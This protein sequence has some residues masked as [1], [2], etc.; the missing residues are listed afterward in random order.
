MAQSPLERMWRERTAKI[1]DEVRAAVRRDLQ[2]VVRGGKVRLEKGAGE[3]PAGSL[4]PE[5]GAPSQQA[6]A[7]EAL[8]AG[9]FVNIHFDGV[10]RVRRANAAN[11]RVAHGYVTQAVA[12]GDTATIYQGGRNGHVSGQQAGATVYLAT[13]AGQATA[14]APDGTG[15]VVQPLGVA[16]S[17]GEIAFQPGTPVYLT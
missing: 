17:A 1:L 7:S 14:S 4:P 11:G 6:D 16:L 12:V 10:A 5:A 3:M 8:A 15:Q 2:G 13:T 9:D